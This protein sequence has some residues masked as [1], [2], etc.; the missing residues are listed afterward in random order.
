MELNEN[1]K[2]VSQTDMSYIHKKLRIKEFK[3][4]DQ[5]FKIKLA[6]IEDRKQYKGYGHNTTQFCNLRHV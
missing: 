3:E 1:I 4:K 5:V 2:D 6:V